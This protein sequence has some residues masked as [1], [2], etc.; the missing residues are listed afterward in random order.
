MRSEDD[1]WGIAESVGVTALGVAGARAMETRRDDGLVSDPYAAAFVDAAAGQVTLP[2]LT[3]DAGP[4]DDP[5]GSDD[6]GQ[7]GARPRI[8]SAY[9]GVRSRF[10]DETLVDAA[11][12]GVRQVVL[13]AAGLDTR[14][15]RLSWPT[16]T[17]IYEIDRS[18][19]LEFKDGVLDGAHS[20]D[21]ADSAGP[22]GS[23]RR[24]GSG[25][26]GG[27]P[28]VEVAAD[29]RHDWPAALRSA[30]FDP[31]QPTAWL[32]EGLLPYLPADAE[33]I[34]FT[35]VRELS[36]PGSRFAVEHFGGA[37]DAI[38]D[39][40]GSHSISQR[41]GIDLRELIYDEPRTDAVERLRA[42]GWTVD[43]HSASALA[44]AWGRPLDASEVDVYGAVRLLD[45][46]LPG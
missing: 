24:S 30:G 21:S 39:N 11:G 9:V 14:A 12:A 10:F 29:L 13:L 31:A 17:V 34:L 3:D 2:G 5:D 1:Q 43:E 45:A 42:D 46:S 41:M 33:A 38:A 16:G 27:G 26:T 37:V 4:T 32:A 28:R 15:L 44:Q 19:V 20:A 8:R 7:P 23:D 36:A 25:P 22:D 18:E 40:Q 35:R 6:R